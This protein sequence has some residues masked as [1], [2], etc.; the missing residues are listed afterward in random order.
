MNNTVSIASASAPATVATA[1]RMITPASFSDATTVV[2]KGAKLDGA[3]TADTDLAL[4]FEGT[5][6]GKVVLNEKGAIHVG[7]GAVIEVEALQADVIYIQGTVKGNVHARK[8]L[9]IGAGA[10]IKGDIRYDEHFDVHNGARING[11][12]NGPEG[13]AN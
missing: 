3:M 2:P 11:S 9:E 1:M 6:K 8:S 10:R 5:F 13:D 7:E 12:I 4:R